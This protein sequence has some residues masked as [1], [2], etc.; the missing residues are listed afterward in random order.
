MPM[1]GLATSMLGA[2]CVLPCPSIRE[3]CLFIVHVL[4]L[5]TMYLLTCNAMSLWLLCA[6]L[7]VGLLCGCHLL[8]MLTLCL[9][10]AILLPHCIEMLAKSLTNGFALVSLS[11]EF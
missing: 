6:W 3:G 5:L 10:D 4:L 2:H 7:I 8:D 11:L 9:L 1:G